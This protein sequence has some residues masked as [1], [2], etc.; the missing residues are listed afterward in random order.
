MPRYWQQV[1]AACSLACLALVGCGSNPRPMAPASLPQLEAP[2]PHPAPPPRSDVDQAG[3]LIKEA[4]HLFD[5]GTQQVARGHLSEARITFDKALSVL[6]SAPAGARVDPRLRAAFDGLVDRISGL[7]ASALA[8]G[9][10]FSER[11]YEAA[12]IDELLAA[13]VFEGSA[14]TAPPELTRTVE[15]DLAATQHD[16]PITPNSRVLAYVQLF[17]GKLRDWMEASLER[18]SR[19][20]PM[21]QN[22]FRAEGLPLDLAYVPLVESAFK[23]SALSR[24][25]ARGVWQ[26]MRDTA[27]ENGLR[28]DWYID[29]RADPEKATVAAAKYLRTLSRMF[30][31]DWHLALASYNGG[32]GRVQRA[33]KRAGSSDFWSLSESP[34]YLPK[35]TREYVPMILAAIII[36]RNPAQYGFTIDTQPPMTYDK[37]RVPR[38][39]DLRRLAEWTDTPVEDLQQLNP[40]LRRWT[41]PAR[42]YELKVPAGMGDAVQARLASL[43]ASELSAVRWHTVKRGDT[44][45][46]LARKFRVSKTELAEA[47]QLG[48]RTRLTPGDSLM[49][50]RAPGP[51]V[52]ARNLRG[53]ERVGVSSR[54]STAGPDDAGSVYVV[55]KGDTLYSIARRFGLSVDAL[56]AANNL[57][58]N[59]IVPGARLSVSAERASTTQ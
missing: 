29:E 34:G 45:T 11:S 40:E 26:F 27:R 30:D 23:P 3:S 9:D 37:V 1:P 56:K 7:E 25:S 50:P 39:T 15:A 10:G 12:S 53:S 43:P 33:V 22:V 59:H 55:R 36:A 52:S 51:L 6:L 57:R 35:E 18:G 47:N 19:F 14:L 20:L 24:A 4:E 42:D 31:G 21:I 8:A 17:S 2:S 54:A 5:E 41:T 38:A 58:A 46:S 16:I 44:L 13:S 32:P 48:V 28:Q 49:I